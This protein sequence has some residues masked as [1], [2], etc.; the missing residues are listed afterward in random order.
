MS[1]LHSSL[2]WK[3]LYYNSP[4]YTTL[5]AYGGPRENSIYYIYHSRCIIQNLLFASETIEP[6]SS[7]H[8]LLIL[9]LWVAAQHVLEGRQA[10]VQVVLEVLV[11]PAHPQVSVLPNDAVR[12]DQLEGGR[13]G[14]REGGREGRREGGREGRKE[15]GSIFV[16]GHQAPT[17]PS[18]SLRRVD[19]PAPFGPTSATLVSRSTPKSIFR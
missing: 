10:E 19:F 4:S 5:D 16:T 14:E 3:C 6:Q 13:E 12:W 7:P 15:R 18:M 1:S 17:S 8:V 9:L 11:V 2:Q